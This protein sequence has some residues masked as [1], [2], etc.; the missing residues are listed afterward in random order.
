[1]AARRS[2]LLP[3]CAA[4]KH[5]PTMAATT[6]GCTP[7]GAEDG[8]LHLPPPRDGYAPGLLVILD[9]SREH[10]HGD[11]GAWVILRKMWDLSLHR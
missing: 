1:M 7:S 11:L 3:L 10:L 2:R 4:Q 8:P 5:C 6:P 9:I